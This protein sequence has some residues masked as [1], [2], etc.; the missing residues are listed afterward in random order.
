MVILVLLVISNTEF[1]Y[2]IPGEVRTNPTNLT[3]RVGFLLCREREVLSFLPV[4]RDF[5]LRKW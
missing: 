4:G 2:K 3:V 5:S 1:T